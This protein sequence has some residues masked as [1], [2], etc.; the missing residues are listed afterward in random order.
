[1]ICQ[2]IHVF[3]RESAVYAAMHAC[4]KGRAGVTSESPGSER[5]WVTK[6]DA[7]EWFELIRD[8]MLSDSLYAFEQE[9]DDVSSTHF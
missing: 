5:G 4:S 6:K 2:V 1:M 7:R 9:V 8:A 3:A